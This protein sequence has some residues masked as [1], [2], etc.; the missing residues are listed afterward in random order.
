M[1]GRA[2]VTGGDQSHVPAVHVLEGVSETQ[3][4]GGAAVDCCSKAVE[5]VEPV[6]DIAVYILEEVAC[7]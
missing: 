1:D 2:V 6:S 5:A 4:L 3:V 7:S